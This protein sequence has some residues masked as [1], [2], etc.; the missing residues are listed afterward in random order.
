MRYRRISDQLRDAD[1]IYYFPRTSTIGM[2]ASRAATERLLLSAPS[3]NLVSPRFSPLTCFTLLLLASPLLLSL[4][5]VQIVLGF[6][7]LFEP[8]VPHFLLF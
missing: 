8:G 1:G 2:A 7:Y 6:I 5:Y 3:S 4:I